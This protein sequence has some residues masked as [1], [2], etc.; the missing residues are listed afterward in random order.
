MKATS[1][2][3]DILI[4]GGYGEVGHRLATQ[5]EVS[6]PNRVIVAGRNPAQARG[7]RA[8]RIDV[9]D[10]DSIERAL[11]GISVVVACVRQRAPH[12]LRAAVRRGIGYTS[13]APPWMPWPETE[14][15]R[16]EAKRSGARVVLAAG[17]EP[18]ITSVLVRAAA[19]RLGQ[20]DVIE[21]ALLLG[22]GDA[23][24]ADSMAFI[25]E[26]IGQR[27]SIIIDGKAHAVHAFERPK[28]VAFPAPIGRRRAYT[29]PFRDQLYYPATLGAKT[30]V[31]R[32]A[33]D[34]PW[35]SSVVAALLRLGLRRALQRGDAR[36]A[37]HGWI[38]K[39]RGRYSGRS[40]YALVVEVRG[41]GRVVRSTL[42]GRE[43]AA[44][45][46]A[47]VGAIVEALWSREVAE[48]GVWLAEEVIAPEPFLA[49]L[50]AHGIVPVIEELPHLGGLDR[51]SAA[52]TDRVPAA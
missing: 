47:G 45:T 17:L 6:S 19:D 33:L 7:V 49:R 48:P 38:E 30:A 10:P 52:R 9:D 2:S 39:L 14:P 12:L 41:A 21:S 44:A 26:E 15:L 46:A 43:Q 35:L 50:A 51:A 11:D 1:S 37:V 16:A 22:L 31:A 27:Y 29:M 28:L 24:G 4:V 5:L 34:P 25:F 8:R 3:N 20:V 18:G 13:I 42:V 40:E 23:Y 32:I 36:G